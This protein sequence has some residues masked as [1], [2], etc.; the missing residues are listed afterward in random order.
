MCQYVHLIIFS[1]ID[2]M[3]I[4]SKQ[5]PGQSIGWKYFAQCR[6]G[7][8]HLEVRDLCIYVKFKVKISFVF[9]LVDFLCRAIISVAKVAQFEEIQLQNVVWRY[10]SS[11]PQ[12]VN[13]SIQ[14]QSFLQNLEHQNY[15]LR[16]NVTSKKFQGLFQRNCGGIAREEVRFLLRW[17]PK[18]LPNAPQC[19]I[20]P[21]FL[22]NNITFSYLNK[23]LYYLY[24]CV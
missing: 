17:S 15:I 12:N 9:F 8:C 1:A 16:W 10:A 13:A 19:H 24:L 4:P 2:K 21:G 5:P 18:C 23:T 11:P 14:T 22:H 20:Y 3:W 7:S 6:F